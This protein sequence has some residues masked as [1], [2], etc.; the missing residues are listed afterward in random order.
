MNELNQIRYDR[1]KAEFENA[2]VPE[3]DPSTPLEIDPDALLTF[4]VWG[5]PQLFSASVDRSV[6]FAAACKDI[7]NIN[8]RLDA[9]ILAG[10]V[11]EFGMECEYK[12]ASELINDCSDHYDRFFAVPGNHDIRIRKFERQFQIF[13]HFVQTVDGGYFGGKTKYFYS[14]DYDCC[15]FI[16]M[17][18]DMNTF[19]GAYYSPAQF[20]FVDEQ[21]TQAEQRGIPAFVINHQTLVKTNGLPVTWGGIGNWRGSVGWQNNKLKAIFEKH[22]NVI[23]I[24]GH[25]HYG[26]SKYSFEDC[27]C[28]KSL[29]VPTVGVV[30]HGDFNYDSQGYVITVYEDKIVFRARLFGEGKYVDKNQPGAEIIIPNTYKE[31][32]VL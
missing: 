5:D 14:Y 29:S 20:R 30:N 13:K 15:K 26:T 32:K 17:G 21:I 24:N 28:F 31:G 1:M 25:L 10:D 2:Q 9:L 18:T 8:G 27:G 22:N 7:K 4:V 23:F 6:R 16:F 12:F 3:P 11:A 19:E